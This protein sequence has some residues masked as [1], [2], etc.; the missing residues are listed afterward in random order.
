MRFV[1]EAAAE[2]SEQLYLRTQCLPAVPRLCFVLRAKEAVMLGQ[3]R[4]SSKY[5]LNLVIAALCIY[6]ILFVFPPLTGW[7]EVLSFL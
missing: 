4:L 7:I 1:S 5:I 3:I 6:Y 2:S